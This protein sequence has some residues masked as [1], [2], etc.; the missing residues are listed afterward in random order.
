MSQ[1]QA[2]P[3]YSSQPSAYDSY[4]GKVTAAVAN[5]A[6]GVAIAMAAMVV[7][8]LVLIYYVHHYKS[9]YDTCSAKSG[10]LTQY[11]MTGLH[12]NWQLGG[13]DA[14]WGGSLHRE[15]TVAQA[16]VYRP[17]S[18]GNYGERAICN[19]DPNCAPPKACAPCS[20][21]N[22]RE[23]MTVGPGGVI[24]KDENGNCS[25]CRGSGV[26]CNDPWEASATA[27]AH[28]LATLG[29]LPH[30]SNADGALQS[31]INGAF[32]C[33]NGLNDSCLNE[34]MHNGGAP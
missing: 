10:Y 19:S 33:K 22:T 28:A 31:T 20:T 2:Y 18:R 21:C 9:L 12:S 4:K 5:N 15:T 29:A 13:G 25:G 6:F 30:D 3:A 11:P 27:E 34:L 14:G 1:P 8:V 32:D 24:M 17:S 7:V 26:C 16:S 23:S